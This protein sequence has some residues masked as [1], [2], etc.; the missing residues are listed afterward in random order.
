MIVFQL[1]GILQKMDVNLIITN[2]DSYAFYDGTYTVNRTVPLLANICVKFI[3]KLFDQGAT[4]D[5]MFFIGYSSGGQ[6]VG[7]M[8][9]QLKGIKKIF[10][11]CE[12]L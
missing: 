6:A 8:G 12:V 10:G 2:W 1:S 3:R 7:L 9:K 11:T 4:A 5:R